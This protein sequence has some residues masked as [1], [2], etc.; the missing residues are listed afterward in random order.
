MK[1]EKI[2]TLGHLN[3]SGVKAN[4]PLQ[5]RHLSCFITEKGKTLLLPKF[6]SLIF[7]EITLNTIILFT[8]TYKVQLF[9]KL[10]P[11]SIR[12][13]DGIYSLQ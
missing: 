7:S 5:V 4:S 1:E 13:D 3:P 11:F 6:T 12:N 10:Q 9:P 2:V 8:L